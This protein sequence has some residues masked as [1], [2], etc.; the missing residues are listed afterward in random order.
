[1]L[2]MFMVARIVNRIPG[3]NASTAIDET[4]VVTAPT[5]ERKQLVIPTAV[6]EEPGLESTRY[7]DVG[8][9]AHI[10]PRASVERSNS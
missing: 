7:T 1:M 10:C 9:K 8:V 4:T 3:P 5:I 6:A 2:A